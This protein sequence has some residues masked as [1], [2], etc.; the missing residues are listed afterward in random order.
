MYDRTGI[1][2][3]IPLTAIGA[4]FAPLS[5]LGGASVAF[6]GVVLWGA[7]LGI[8]ET[9]MAAAVADMVPAG[10]TA[11]AYGLFT[12]AFGLAWFAG[13]AILGFAYD[14][15]VVAT[16]VLA[17]ML[18]LAAV[19]LLVWVAMQRRRSSPL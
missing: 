7:A 10:R 9:I 2:L 4:M 12:M 3:L 13:S 17:L 16:A 11:S 6:I 15:S 5:F 18:Q 1:G 19:P 8:H 14:R